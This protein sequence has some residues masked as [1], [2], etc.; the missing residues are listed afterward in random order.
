[1]KK[2]EGRVILTKM[3]GRS[4]EVC[5][6][7]DGQKIVYDY[8]WFGDGDNCLGTIEE[9]EDLTALREAIDKI[10]KLRSK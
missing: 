5:L 9:S 8:L 10:L 2:N 6:P 3:R 7:T 4:L 1:M